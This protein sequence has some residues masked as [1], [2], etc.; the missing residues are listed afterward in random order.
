MSSGISNQRVIFSDNGTLS[1]FSFEARDFRGDS[2]ATPIVAAEDKI[3]IGTTLPFNHKW[4]EI[5]TVNDAAS[6]LSVDV[7]DGE[8]W[9]PTVSTFDRTDSSGV[10]LAQSGYI[11]FTP[12]RDEAW[13]REQDSFEVEGLESTENVNEIYQMYWMRLSFSAD[14][15]PATSIKY[16]GHKFSSDDDLY[17]FYP[18]L[19]NSALKTQFKSGKTNWDEQS[20]MSS[21]FIIKELKSRSI[22]LN[23]DQIMDFDLFQEA[24]IHKIAAIIY[25]AL[26]DDFRDDYKQSL[27]RF[28]NS[29]NL[30][31]FNIDKNIDGRLNLAEKAFKTGFNRR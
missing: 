29:M 11:M 31:Q 27:E 16:I 8:S 4:I 5:S 26:G 23:Q 25:A 28:N 17:A 30:K 6:V 10:S 19:N 13:T 15:H 12:D 20:F 24:S 7:W 18:D 14:L 21:Q 22:I 2:I 9:I 1:D 3:Y